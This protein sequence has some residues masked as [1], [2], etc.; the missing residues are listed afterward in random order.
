MKTSKLILALVVAVSFGTVSSSFAAAKT[1][2]TVRI[3]TAV[4]EKSGS[5]RVSS[6]DGQ[7][8]SKELEKRAAT[9][10]FRVAS[11]K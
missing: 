1:S 4:V 10:S 5:Q 7:T 8:Y 3:S 9:A 2:S 6:Q 11:L